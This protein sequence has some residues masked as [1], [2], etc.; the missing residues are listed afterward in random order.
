MT[1]RYR[2][3]WVP[4]NA[5]LVIRLALEEMGVPYDTVLVDRSS[6][7]HKAA[8]YLK[9]N[10]A[11]LIP[12]L[13]T[14][15]GPIFETAAI[16][17]WLADRHRAMAPSPDHP[18]RGAF[19]KY[20]FFAS[21]TLHAAARMRFYPN[22]YLGS[23]EQTYTTLTTYLQGE[24]RRH[25]DLMENAYA[26]GDGG[27]GR[28]ISVIDV[29]VACICRWLMLY[30]KDEEKEWCEISTW[31]HLYA[32]TER[33]EACECT[34]AAITAEGLGPNPFTCPVYPSPPEGSVM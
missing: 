23:A 34:K 1:D 30:P 27:L 4:D 10:P 3:H 15:D 21:N 31:P 32:M 26:T 12:A 16:L 33:L 22:Q 29:Y 6:G 11:G 5:S 18:D 7:A 8:A 2:L 19:L 14:P 17:L 20:L 25:L 9:I 13:E 24:L 28:S